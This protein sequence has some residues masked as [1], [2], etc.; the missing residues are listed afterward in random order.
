[1]GFK[2]AAI[3]RVIIYSCAMERHTVLNTLNLLLDTEYIFENIFHIYAYFFLVNFYLFIYF[4][5][6][7]KNEVLRKHIKTL[8]I[9]SL[10]ICHK[11]R[12]KL[13]AKNNSFLL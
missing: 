12:V 13:N 5:F 4:L 3:V 8:I 1:M 9:D 6:L 2:S 10:M 7:V 11:S